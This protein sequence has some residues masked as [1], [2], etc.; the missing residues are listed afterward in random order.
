MSIYSTLRSIKKSKALSKIRPYLNLLYYD[1]ENVIIKKDNFDTVSVDGVHFHMSDQ[2]DSLQRVK[3]NPWFEGVRETDIV[4]DIGANIG[5]IAIPLAKTAK[6]VYA[7]EPLFIDELQKNIELNCLQTKVHII[8]F[9]V[10]K[11]NYSEEVEF[12][13]KKAIVK[14]LTLGQIFTQW[15]GMQVNFIKIDGEG[16]EWD[17]EPEQ[18]TGIREIRIEFHLRRNHKMDDK[19]KL[20]KYMKWFQ[21]N[22]YE[23]HQE[24]GKTPLCVPFTACLVVRASKK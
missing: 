13:S 17:I 12:S 10:G 24:W 4:L 19:V 1:P 15:I 23:V 6:R 5:A 9:A 16:C 2:I 7:V 8:P 22:D 21:A 20:A 14:F 18:L 11:D 3:N